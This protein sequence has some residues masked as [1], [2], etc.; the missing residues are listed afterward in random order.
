MLDSSNSTQG[1]NTIISHFFPQIISNFSSFFKLDPIL[2]DF[3]LQ[4]IMNYFLILING[5][6]A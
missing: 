1:S 5:C 3:A 4:P 6:F 2:H